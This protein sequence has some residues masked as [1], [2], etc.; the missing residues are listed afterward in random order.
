M[1]QTGGPSFTC[2]QPDAFDTN[3]F[4]TSLAAGASAAFTETATASPG[5]GVGTILNTRYT[6]YLGASPGGT[7]YTTTA[8]S[9]QV[10][11]A[12][13]P[14]QTTTTTAPTTTGPRA[15]SITT[16]T[17]TTTTT[18]HDVDDAPGLELDADHD[19]PVAALP[20]ACRGRPNA[21][22]RPDARRQRRLQAGAL[23]RLQPE[24]GTG[25]GDPA[26]TG[27]R[28]GAGTAGK[29]HIVISRGPRPKRR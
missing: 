25:P 3:C 13:P 26:V 8:S 24:G 19:V 5:A 10:V 18:T 12:A 15:P 11:A 27:R 14:A 23:V 6:V 7:A 4:L 28:R 1:S 16:S 17:S 22:H 20:G 21:R 9:V 29:G 2:T